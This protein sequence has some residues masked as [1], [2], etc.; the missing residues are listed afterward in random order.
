MVPSGGGVQVAGKGYGWNPLAGRAIG[1]TPFHAAGD[2]SNGGFDGAPTWPAPPGHGDTVPMQLHL[3]DAT[4]E[5]FRAHFGRPPSTDVRGR[6][7]GATIG[8]VESVLRLMRDPGVTHLGCATDHVIRSWRNERY[9]GYKTEAGMPPELLAQFELAEE[10]LR[11]L[12]L[13][14]WPMIEYEADD[15][16]ATAAAR[17]ADSPGMERVVILSPDKDLAQC[18]RQDGRVVAFDRR[19]ERTIDADAVRARFGVDPE[20]IPDWLALVGDA[21]DGFPGLRGWGERSASAVLNRYVHLDAIPEAAR[22][23]DV[24]VRNADALAATLRTGRAEAL[25]YR[26][27]A[28]LRT[29][30]PL[31]EELDDLT[32]RGVPREP[33]SRLVSELRAPHL[34]GRVPR[35]QA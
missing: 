32:W 14:V 10:A 26:E 20:S 17:W 7:A 15:A 6:P 30:V 23:W 18:V 8:L 22:A 2:P 3:L 35:W 25:L 24:S 21:A 11:A 27:L 16:L 4:Y 12:G 34:L 1:P 28:T 19:R 31:P 33:F 5:L 29:D 9:A 13:V